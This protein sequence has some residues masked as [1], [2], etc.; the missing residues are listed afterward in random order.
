MSGHAIMPDFILHTPRCIEHNIHVLNLPAHTTHLLQVADIAVFGPFK[1][2]I[3]KSLAVYRADHGPYIPPKYYAKATRTAWEK[4]TTR[5]NCI[6][7]FEK[8]GIVPFDRTKITAKIYKEGA[9]L[10]KLRDDSSPHAP[11]V[12]VHV[13]TVA[14]DSLSSAAALLTPPSVSVETVSSVLSPPA[15]HVNPAPVAQRRVGIPTTFARV[16][17][18]EQSMNII[19]KR[20]QDKENKETEKKERKQKKEEKQAAAAAKPKPK[21][22]N[23]VRLQSKQRKPLSNIT[24]TTTTSSSMVDDPYDFNANYGDA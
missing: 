23:S 4:A 12:A 7:G 21:P 6:A 1:K 2:Y 20:Q 15:L 13:S 3:A 9:Q 14:L 8:A 16:L 5:A 11:P 19:R 10:R 22:K 24:N 18:S 17:T